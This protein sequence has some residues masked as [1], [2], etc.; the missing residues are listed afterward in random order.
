MG[1]CQSC[2]A[3]FYYPLYFLIICYVT[4]PTDGDWVPAV[5]RFR[6]NHGRKHIFASGDIF[7]ECAV[8]ISAIGEVV[9]RNSDTV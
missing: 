6:A 3:A 5:R 7:A 4:V 9:C 1:T 8:S 2:V